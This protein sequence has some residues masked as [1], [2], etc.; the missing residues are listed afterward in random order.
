MYIVSFTHFPKITWFFASSFPFF[1]CSF[2]F[3][4]SSAAAAFSSFSFCFFASLSSFSRSLITFRFARN[5]TMWPRSH[6][7]VRTQDILEMDKSVSSLY[8]CSQFGTPSCI[9][10]LVCKSGICHNESKLCKWSSKGA[11]FFPVL[12]V[13][14]FQVHQSYL[15]RPVFALKSCLLLLLSYSCLFC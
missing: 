14:R 5:S 2:V 11:V 12:L 7:H 10:G 6:S 8:F 15:F 1:F 9:S 3:F 4:F 13:V